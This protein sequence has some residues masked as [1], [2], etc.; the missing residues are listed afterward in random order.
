MLKFLTDF[1]TEDESKR[2]HFHIKSMKTSRS[3][4][5]PNRVLSFL[6]FASGLTLISAAAAMAFV[7]AKPSVPLLLSKSDNPPKT[8]EKFRQDSDEL[9]GNKV[10]RPGIS[11][12]K[13]P[14]AAAVQNAQLRS[15]PAA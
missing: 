11:R 10:T 9:F 12:D 5:K 13:G 6:R 2:S 4:S 8:I 15:Y 14:A 3:F 1:K 7:A